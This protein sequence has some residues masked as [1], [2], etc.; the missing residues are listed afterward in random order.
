MY[1]QK[2]QKWVRKLVHIFKL[3]LK[4]HPPTCIFLVKQFV[5]IKAT[6]NIL[7]VVANN[8]ISKDEKSVCVPGKS[9]SQAEYK[10]MLTKN[11]KLKITS[12]N[13]KNVQHEIIKIISSHGIKLEL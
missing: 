8:W 10:S 2:H 1:H 3:T 5:L 13:P 6:G 11:A 7:M 9:S 12:K 4:F